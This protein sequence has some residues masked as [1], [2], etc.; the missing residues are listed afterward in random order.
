MSIPP[1]VQAHLM[2]TFPDNTMGVD[3]GGMRTIYIEAGRLGPTYVGYTAD[4]ESYTL[5][6][7]GLVI[8]LLLCAAVIALTTIR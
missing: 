7:A 5:A 6:F 1:V 8:C 3:L 2:D 4:L